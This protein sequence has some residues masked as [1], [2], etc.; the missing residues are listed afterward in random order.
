MPA[1]GHLLANGFRAGRTW[2]FDTTEPTRPKVITSFGGLAGFTHPHNFVR[3]PNG[4]LLTTFQYAATS[5]APPAHAH[6]TAALTPAIQ[7]Q[8]AQTGGLVEMDER[9]TV[10]RGRSARDPAIADSRLYPCSVLPISRARSRSPH[11]HRHEQREQS[12][13]IGVGAVL[14]PLRSLVAK[15]HRAPAWSAGPRASFH[16]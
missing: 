4:N 16:G 1:N 13:D 6:G 14:A 11:H 5:G 9:G 12:R 7:E 3:L 10:I 15:E 2:L 8:E